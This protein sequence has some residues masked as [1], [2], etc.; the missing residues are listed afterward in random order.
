[1]VNKDGCQLSPML[2]GR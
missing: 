2:T 1:M